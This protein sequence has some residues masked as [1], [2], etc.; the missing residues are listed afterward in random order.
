MMAEVIDSLWPYLV[1]ILVGV[2]PNEVFR[3]AGVVL[4]RAVD[5]RS[6]TFVWVRHVATAL[7]AGLIAKLLF[8]P[9]SMLATVPLGLRLG[10]VALGVGAFFV[11]RRSVLFGI[12]CGEA[13]LVAA[14]WAVTR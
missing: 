14:A 4:A 13:A 10:A 8:S 7:L 12:L 5:D 2:L 6:Q 1:L 3:L 9:A 11:G